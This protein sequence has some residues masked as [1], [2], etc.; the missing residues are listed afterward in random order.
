M[1]RIHIKQNKLLINKHKDVG[2]KNY[3]NPKVFPEN[4]NNMDDTSEN[5]EEYNLNKELKTLI[6][7]D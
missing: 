6:V 3:N 2:L 5:I 1:L 4:S 7:F